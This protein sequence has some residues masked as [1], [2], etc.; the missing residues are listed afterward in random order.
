MEDKSKIKK[1]TTHIISIKNFQFSKKN[2]KI[3]KNDK[4]EYTIQKN[5]S[6]YNTLYQTKN[7]NFILYIEET[8]TQLPTLYTNKKITYKFSENGKYTIKCLNYPRLYQYIL[9]KEDIKNESLMETGNDT[10]NLSFLD[11]SY[12]N[13]LTSEESFFQGDRK[14]GFGQ[15]SECLK[16][17]NNGF[18]ADSIKEKY[19]DIFGEK[20]NFGFCNS[21]KLDFLGGNKKI[22][23][24]CIEKNF[25]SKD[26]VFEENIKDEG[27]IEYKKIKYDLEFE[28]KE[29]FDKV[30]NQCLIVKE[31]DIKKFDENKDLNNEQNISN[32]NFNKIKNKNKKKRKKKKKNKKVKNKMK[33]ERSI[34]Y[35]KK[36]SSKSISLLKNK[37]IERSLSA[38]KKNKKKSLSLYK[39]KTEKSNEKKQE[40]FEH[41]FSVYKLNKMKPDNLFNILTKIKRKYISSPQK[42]KNIKFFSSFNSFFE[43]CQKNNKIDSTKIPPLKVQ[44]NKIVYYKQ[45]MLD[46]FTIE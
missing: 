15:I 33:K 39:K 18:S 3:N 25:E 4:I 31:E 13:F 7:R 44:K 19:W 9:V 6:N 14:G 8:N 11:K 1:S 46:R 34:S 41:L 21:Q 43:F 26:K 2:L 23:D 5:R 40:D 45:K 37:K 12:S 17:M 42:K 36:K 24:N 22:E 30:L 35:Q 27:F 32:N 38:E 16:L 29:N 10:D 28:K 20:K